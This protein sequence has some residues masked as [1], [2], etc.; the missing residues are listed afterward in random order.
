MEAVAEAEQRPL[1]QLLQTQRPEE[2]VVLVEA[3]MVGWPL[4][5]Q[6]LL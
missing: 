1:D 4:L 5:D 3:E 6:P 2:R